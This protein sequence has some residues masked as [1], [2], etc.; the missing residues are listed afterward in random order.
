MPSPERR[1]QLWLG[2][3]PRPHRQQSILQ[4]QVP[5]TGTRLQISHSSMASMTVNNV[6]HLFNPALSR[7]VGCVRAELASGG[8]HP[9]LHPLIATPVSTPIACA[10]S[11]C[12]YIRKYI[13]LHLQIGLKGPCAVPRSTVYS[14]VQY[15][16]RLLR[17]FQQFLVMFL[18]QS[19]ATWRLAHALA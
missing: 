2:C 9:T 8:T 12:Y 6:M 17:T 10:T 13:R 18:P 3:W 16:A 7:W 4:T 14:T 19:H 1:W 15:A 5:N 11:M